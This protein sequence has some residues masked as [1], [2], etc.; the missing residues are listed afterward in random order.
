MSQEKQALPF[1]TRYLENQAGDMTAEELNQVSGGAS[2]VT[3]M[4]PSDGDAADSGY[5][6]GKPQ[7]PFDIKIDFPAF[8][9]TFPFKK[10]FDEGFNGD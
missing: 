1:F 9:N 10:G 7:N 8:P 4:Y 6:G 5:P 2:A 3:E